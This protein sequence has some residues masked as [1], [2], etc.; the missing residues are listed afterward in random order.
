MNLIKKNLLQLSVVLFIVLLPVVSFAQQVTPI[1]CDPS[2]GKI[3]NPLESSG[4]NTVNDFIK[5]LLD[6]VLELGIP[7]VALAIIYSG[8]L[9]V[10]ARGNPESLKKAKD[11]L[12]YSIIGAAV[13]LGAWSIAQLIS[14]TVFSL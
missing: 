11:A 4:V 1:K 6:G 5:V 12:L 10:S 9:F 14:T 3:C 13:L 8:F 2:K 7:L